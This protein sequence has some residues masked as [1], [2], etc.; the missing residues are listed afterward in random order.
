MPLTGAP[1]SAPVLVSP[2]DGVGSIVIVSVSPASTGSPVG[3]VPTADAVF[4]IVPASTSACVTTYVAVP[5]TCAPGANTP[6]AP[7]HDE[8][9]TSDRPTIGSDTSTPVSVTL[10][11]F[12]T[13]NEYVT[14]CPAAITEP[15][16]D[17]FTNDNDGVGS[18]VI[19]SVSPA[20][21]GS[22][23]GGVPTADAVFTIVPAS[24]SAC[25]TTYVAVP[26]TCAPGANTPAAPGHDENVTSDRPTI[27][28]DT[29]TPVSVTLP[30][31][32]TKN[33]Y[34]T[35]CPAAITE[36]G[37]DDFTNDNDG[38]AA[39]GTVE[40][41]PPVTGGPDGGVPCTDAEFTTEPESM[42][43]CASV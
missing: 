15:G 27:G 36:P 39:T 32:V 18:I 38:V 20:S 17:D 33:E 2:I 26:V 29:S 41:S 8:N 28:S 42:S 37:D 13:K 1:C 22:P 35:V 19:V 3:G 16:D 40:I 25:V 14:V 31:F 43:A 11:V 5:V 34:V 23:V 10:P 9:V 6:A 30:V 21:T 12:V 24:T 4:T 7:G